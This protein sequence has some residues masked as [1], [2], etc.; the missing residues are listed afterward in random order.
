VAAVREAG[1]VADVG[2]DP[3]GSGRP[4]PVDVHQARPG[5]QDRGLEL[6]FDGLQLDV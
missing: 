3:G 6:G 1:D 4:D 2:Q 5:R